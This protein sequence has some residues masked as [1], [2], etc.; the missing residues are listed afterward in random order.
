MATEQPEK[1]GPGRPRKPRDPEVEA[2]KAAER[3]AKRIARE[4]RAMAAKMNE[5]GRNYQ[6]VPAD[7]TPLD[8]LEG[9]FRGKYKGDPERIRCAISAAKYRHV[10]LHDGGKKEAAQDKAAE[11]SQGKYAP[12]RAPARAAV[13]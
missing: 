2:A 11:V 3:E 8:Y 1:R 13:H 5:A 4:A 9:V 7:C 6:E 10:S 12:G